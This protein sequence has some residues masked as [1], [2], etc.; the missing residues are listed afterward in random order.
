MTVRSFQ[1][2]TL[3]PQNY[4]TRRL[5]VIFHGDAEFEIPL[6]LPIVSSKILRFE[7]WQQ[8][9]KLADYMLFTTVMSNS[10]TTSFYH[11]P[12]P[13]YGGS[14]F[15][16]FWN[17]SLRFREMHDF[18][19][20]RCVGAKCGNRISLAFTV[21]EISHIWP[22]TFNLRVAGYSFLDV[23]YCANSESEIIFFAITSIYAR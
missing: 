17:S 21:L 9:V 20:F 22:L 5:Y 2:L 3:W 8:I 11:L 23:F 4:Q 12:F 19:V 1:M 7:F 14:N 6:L 18:Y 15:I 13:R 10:K 16:E